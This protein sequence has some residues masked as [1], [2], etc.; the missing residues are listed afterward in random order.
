MKRTIAFI[1]CILMLLAFCGCDEGRP[2]HVNNST[3]STTPTN[4]PVRAM[5]TVI[6]NVT[7]ADVWILPDTEENRSTTVWGTATAAGVKTGERRSITLPEA[8]DEGL[9]LLRMIDTDEMYYS[10]SAVELKEGWT[11]EIRE[12][13]AGP[14]TAKVTDED[15][16]VQCVYDVFSAHL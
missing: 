4:A 1:T 12:A 14:I 3:Q 13:D 11:I 2:S 8:G 15:G 9:Y 5:L 16:D 7:E 6:N 10:A